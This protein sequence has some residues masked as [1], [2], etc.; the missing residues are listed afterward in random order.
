MQSHWTEHVAIAVTPQGVAI[1]PV[2]GAMDTPAFDQDSFAFYQD[3]TES[4]ATQ[5]GTTNVDPTKGD[6]DVDTT[7]LVRFLVQ[8]T[9]GASSSNEEL[10]L[11]YRIDT[12]GGFGSWLDVD[13]A[14]SSVVIPAGTGA[15][16]TEDGDTTQ[17]IGGGTFISTNG[18]QDEVDGMTA[19]NGIDFTGSD[20]V[21]AVFAFQLVSG[22]VAEDDDIELRVIRNAAG[23]TALD[24]YTN[25]P[26]ITGPAQAQSFSITG[27]TTVT[28]TPA[29]GLPLFDDYRQLLINSITSDASETNGWDNEKSNLSVTD[30]VRTSDTVVTITLSALGDYS[31]TADETLTVLVPQ[32]MIDNYTDGDV[33]GAPTFDITNE[34]GEV[35][36]A[37]AH[38]APVGV[39][40][41]TAQI[42][43]SGTEGAPSGVLAYAGS[44]AVTG[45]QGAPS[46]GLLV[47]W[48]EEIAGAK[49]A[50]SGEIAAGL[51]QALTGAAGAPSG[52]IN[53]TSAQ[54][55]TGAGG[56]PSGALAHNSSIALDGAK[57]AP[58]GALA[59]NGQFAVAGTKG[60]PSG[61]VGATI[62]QAESA[63]TLR[64]F[65]TIFD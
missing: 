1:L 8:E 48:S 34:E 51:T 28:L 53:A 14:P 32:E 19:T 2:A 47:S 36:L 65:L 44:I 11:Q 59:M 50:P 23:G 54:A 3:G 30:V 41:L 29:A 24:T 21:E 13:N 15:G 4:G 27:A 22:D 26:S 7:Y 45:T 55:L 49:G 20:E 58:S 35:A 25:T 62:A 33:T 63:E 43:L 5:I 57:G 10:Q 31:I 17:R 38:G 64:R 56:A 39:L 16:L 37:G 60:A 9:A 12:G 42:A 52:D 18:S 46:G 61:D 40:A 6:I